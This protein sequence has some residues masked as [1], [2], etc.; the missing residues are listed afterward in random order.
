[1]G[2]GCMSAARLQSQLDTAHPCTCTPAPDQAAAHELT[3][4]LKLQKPALRQAARGAKLVRVHS[5]RLANQ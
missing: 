4:L 1:M 5:Q 3:R 2:T